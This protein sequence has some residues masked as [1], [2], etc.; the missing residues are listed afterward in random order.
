MHLNQ[1]QATIEGFYHKI[2]DIPHTMRDGLASTTFESTTNEVV[3]VCEVIE[4]D[5]LRLISNARS[6]VLA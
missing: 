3:D 5:P 6:L 4:R 2:N 1:S